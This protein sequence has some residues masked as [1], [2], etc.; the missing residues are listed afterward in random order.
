MRQQLGERL[1]PF[2]IR[3]SP[4][5]A[6]ALAE[7]MTVMDY[8]PD[9]AVAEDYRNLAKWARTPAAPAKLGRKARWSER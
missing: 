2:V 4:S 9:A 1:L 8:A 7:G 5:V 3:R 6:E